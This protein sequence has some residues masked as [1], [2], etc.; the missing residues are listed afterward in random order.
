MTY[1]A[2]Q[3]ATLLGGTVQGDASVPLTGFA[4]ADR[5]GVGDLTF[6]E[7]AAYFSRAE[8]SAATAIMVDGDF[9]SPRKILIRVPHSRVAF[10]RVLPLFF[11]EPSFPPGIHPTSVVDATSEIDPTAHIGPGCIVGARARVGPRSVVEAGDVLGAEVR[12]GADVRIFPNVTLYPGVQIGDRVRIHA[13]AVIGSDGFGYVLYEGAHL[14]IPQIG[15]V[16]IEEDVEIGANVTIDRGALGA[17][18]VGKGT[19]IDNLVHLGHNVRVGQHCI[20][21]AQAGIAG[22]TR[23]GQHVT[24]A[25]QAGLSGHLKIGDRAVVAAQA[26]VMTD[27]PEGEKWMGS[28][29]R[30]SLQAR[31]LFIAAEQLPDILKRL[32]ALEKRLSPEP[33]LPISAP[34]Q[35]VHP[36]QPV[37][38]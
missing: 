1:T 36:E 4:P 3:I 25:G 8:E 5:A 9:N 19:K 6:A 31:R 26:G 27:I 14:K 16:L 29:A 28:P 33:G 24:I 17:T 7:T 34:T 21:I 2:G 12:L 18:I 37:V 11:P 13:G 22:S 30:R 32:A 10:A 20:L 15:S 38:E 23:L 35:P